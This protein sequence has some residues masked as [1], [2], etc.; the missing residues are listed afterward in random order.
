MT[1]TEEIALLLMFSILYRWY[2]YRK[3]GGMTGDTLGAANEVM[4]I[5]FYFLLML[6]TQVVLV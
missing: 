3:I 5:L 2:I 1:A 6:L 4:E